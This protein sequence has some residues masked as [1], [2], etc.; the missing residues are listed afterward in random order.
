MLLRTEDGGARDSE[1]MVENWGDGTVC[2]G[3]EGS[4]WFK[5]LDVGKDGR[6]VVLQER[7]E[8][9]LTQR[10][11]AESIREI[12]E[13]EKYPRPQDGVEGVCSVARL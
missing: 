4:G 10:W 7:D 2:I 5:V 9:R 8:R 11:R 13:E 1:W 12:L 3:Y 6:E